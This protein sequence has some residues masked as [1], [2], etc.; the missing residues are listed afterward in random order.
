MLPLY[1]TYYPLDLGERLQKVFDTGMT[2]EGP[3]AAAFQ[4]ELQEWMC[5][6]NVALMSSGTM[7]LEIAGRLAGVGPGDEIICSSVTCLAG[8]GWILLAGATPVWCDINPNTGCINHTKIEELITTKT[9]AITFVDWGGTPAELLEIQKIADEYGIKTIQD[10]A[11]SM[12]ALY[13]GKKISENQICD[14]LIHS[15][16]SIKILSTV[17]GGC[18]SCKTKE[19]FDRAILLRWFGLARGQNSH[20]VCWTGDVTEP[21]YKGHMNDINAAIGREQLKTV[22][23]RIKRHKI[24]GKY[25]QEQ[26]KTLSPKL[27]VPQI[28]TYI[29]SNYWVFT[30][31]LENKEHRAIVSKALTNAGIGN[32]ISHVRNDKYSLFKDY[33]K[34][35][36]S[37]SDYENRRLNIPCGWWLQKT[38]LDYI[39][40]VLQGVINE[41]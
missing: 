6:P 23:E 28:P 32:N 4:K 1:K 24:N 20:S 38:D 29:E 9:K 40:Q 35:L 18:L 31:R 3:E 15:F 13:N 14:Y 8:T 33:Q 21:G 34:D 25:L 10:S 27:L 30:I 22:D 2:S 12:G 37:V 41:S 17:D 36:P 39:V 26:L 16:Q 19:D 7:A 5:N 11:Q